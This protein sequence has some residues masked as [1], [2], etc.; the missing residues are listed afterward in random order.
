MAQTVRTGSGTVWDVSVSQC[1]G[2]WFRKVL[3]A[4]RIVSDGLV[5][6]R[7]VKDDTYIVWNGLRCLGEVRNG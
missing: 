5:W 6:F 2:E 7:I 1:G 3:S 4:L